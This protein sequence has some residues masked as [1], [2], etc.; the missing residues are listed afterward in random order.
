MAKNNTFTVAEV[1]GAQRKSPRNYTHAI[2]GRYNWTAQILRDDKDSPQD[3]D[4]YRFYA[5]VVR[6]GIGGQW[7]PERPWS[8]VDE[9]LYNRAVVSIG[10][11]TEDEYAAHCRK[12]RVDYATRKRD[13]EGTKLGVLQW[14][15]SLVN[16]NKG[17]RTWVN[18]GYLDVRVVE[19]IKK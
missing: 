6:V 3:R 14:S 8:K 19:T 4:N 11:R 5:S 12:Y 7:D 13:E 16:A 10:G 18:N 1:P 9:D 15:Q 17:A 2:L